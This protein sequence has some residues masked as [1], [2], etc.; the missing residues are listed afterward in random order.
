MSLLSVKPRLVLVG[1]HMEGPLR[2][3]RSLILM[4]LVIS[5]PHGRSTTGRFRQWPPEWNLQLRTDAAQ[6]V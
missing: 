4:R 5:A 6:T 1:N 2:A 3:R